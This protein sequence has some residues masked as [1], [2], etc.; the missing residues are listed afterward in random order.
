MDAITPSKYSL[1]MRM[2]HWLMAALIVTLVG[3]GAY[4][5]DIPTDAPNKY[6]LYPWHKS[7][8][9]LVLV[10]VVVRILVRKTS[11]LPVL[12]TAFSALERK[13]IG[14]GHIVLYLL[15]IVTPIAGYF[16]SC[17]AGAEIKFFG[18]HLPT[19]LEKNEAL[20]ENLSDVHGTLA[21]TLIV[22]AGIHALAA[23]KHVFDQNPERNILNRMR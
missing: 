1:L 15:M 4:M 5:A 14:A 12:P 17:A 19:V 13:L 16:M 18:V 11:V 2:L 20:F 21:W 10:L 22:V 23:I 8:G 7:F 6:L 3:V 9:L